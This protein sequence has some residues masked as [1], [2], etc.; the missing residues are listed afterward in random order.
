VRVG[1]K[2][3]LPFLGNERRAEKK[4][5]PI[6]PPYFK[7]GWTRS[8]RGGFALRALDRAS[9]PFTVPNPKFAIIP[10]LPAITPRQKN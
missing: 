8:G 1:E 4:Y 9:L 5:L 3:G 6:S 10:Y 7:E 2:K